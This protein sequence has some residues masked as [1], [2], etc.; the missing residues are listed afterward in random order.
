MDAWEKRLKILVIRLSAIG[1]VIHCLPAAAILKRAFPHAELVW[2]VEP[3]SAQLLKEN[4]GVD[5]VIVFPAKLWLKEAGNPARWSASVKEASQFFKDLRDERFDLALDM[6]GL[7]KSGMLAFASGAK[8]KAGFAGTR[9]FAEQFLTHR[10]NV[11]D[12][13]GHFVPVIDM[14]NKLAE[15]AVQLLN[16]QVVPGPVV[17]PLPPAQPE[18]VAKVERLINGVVPQAGS[19]PATGSVPGAESVPKAGSVPAAGSVP[20]TESVPLAESVPAAGA[21][22]KSSGSLESMSEKGFAVFDARS[23][24]SAS[25]PIIRTAV[26]IP[27][28]TWSTKIWPAEKWV[29]L[30]Q[31]LVQEFNCRI[32]FIGG[33]LEAE[34]NRQIVSQLTNVLAPSAIIDLTEETTLLDLVALFQR[35]DLVVGPDTGPL[36]LAVA[37]G[38]PKVLG[39]YGATPWRRLGPY[40]AQCRSVSLSLECQP[41]YA[42]HCR[43]QTIACLND[44]SVEH[45][46]G[47]L[48]ALLKQS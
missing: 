7:F 32:V 40:G 12:Y 20:G 13:F 31:R 22:D 45:V 17:F 29:G 35:V 34:T 39:I 4:P 43:L 15:F 9:E 28:T 1:D 18:S 38:I 36:H 30:A 11:G 21:S 5:R 48:L 44:L 14:N 8:I 10:L 26:F 46:M 6:Q 42:K 27:G 37:V 16:G 33:K 3:F 23:G 24:A 25:L 47:E 2:L 41:C 19:I